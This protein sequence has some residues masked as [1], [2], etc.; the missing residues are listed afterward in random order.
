[1]TSELLRSGATIHELNA[2]RSRLSTLKGGG[3]LQLL[4]HTTVMNLIVS[5]VL[6][7]DLS[8]IASGPTVPRLAANRPRQCWIDSAWT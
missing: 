7:D 5:D 2:V 4:R 8:V 1:M 3:L 6:G